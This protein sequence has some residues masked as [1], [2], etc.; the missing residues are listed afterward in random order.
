METEDITRPLHQ[1]HAHERAS[2]NRWIGAE[3][4]RVQI[5][6]IYIGHVLAHAPSDPDGAWPH[7]VVR[8]EIERLASNDVERAIQME[9]FNMRGVYSRSMYQGGDEERSFAKAA[10]DAA[11][12]TSPWPRTTALLRTIGEGWEQD[13]KRADLDAAQRRLRS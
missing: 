5:T 10:Y 6:D 1:F 9:R 11:A 12:I 7:R 8:D 4:D 13:A 3:T 2:A